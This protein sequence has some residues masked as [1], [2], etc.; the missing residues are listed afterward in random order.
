M[1]ELQLGLC[2]LGTGVCGYR[3]RLMLES[4]N[5]SWTPACSGALGVSHDVREAQRDRR[6]RFWVFFRS[7]FLSQ[8]ALL[9]AHPQSRLRSRELWALVHLRRS[10][11]P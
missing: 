4:R 7:Q 5:A 6:L 2:L 1:T 10:E 3:D 9:Q 8:P 11:G